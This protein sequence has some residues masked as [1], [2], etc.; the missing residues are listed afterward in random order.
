[1]KKTLIILLLLPTTLWAQDTSGRSPRVHYRSLRLPS[2]AITSGIVA[3]LASTYYT[4]QRP[5]WREIN[6]LLQW[7]HNNPAGT[8][9][10]AAAMDL[11]F[12]VG[13][14]YLARKLVDGGHTKWA[15]AGLYIGGGIRWYA[16]I[17]NIT[18]GQ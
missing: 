10:A 14:R 1:M 2:V 3:D 18:G 5:G 15:Q 16:A 11:G 8:V 13:W 4:L 17:T 12:S 7:T 9:A 6:P